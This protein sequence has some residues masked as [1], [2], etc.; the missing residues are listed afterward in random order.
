[1]DEPTARDI[2]T[3]RSWVAD[4]PPGGM[5]FFGGAG[6]ST[7]SG[8]PDFRS[9]DGLYAQKYPY[10]PEQMISR[11]FFD[12]HPGAFFDFYCDRMLALD[13]QPN[14]AHRKLAELE[15][16]G[17]LS[18]VV[19]QNIDGLHQKAGS[20]NVFEL[21]GSVLR[22]FCMGCRAP[23]PVQDL[24]ALRAQA[25]DGVPR[26]PACGGIVKPDVVLY[27]EPLDER[28]MQGA[29]DA[30]AQADLLV[31]AGTSLAVYPAAGLI[32]FFTGRRLVIV[33]RTPTPRDRQ[34]DLCI[35]ANVGDVF[36]F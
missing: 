7:E 5:V 35:A 26:C 28:T 1:M 3:F 30:L 21:H 9:P 24:L 34:A 17:T 31:V 11:S 4:T 19:T 25:P 6:V 16:A 23:Y 33:N 29:V 14:R 18:A 27:E 13:A 2:D 8:I 12:A 20:A 10:P 32:D 15:Q 22:N 36:D